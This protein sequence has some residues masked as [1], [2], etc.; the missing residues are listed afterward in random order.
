MDKIA[1]AKSLANDL[2]K[3]LCTLETIGALVAAAHLDAAVASLRQ[4][5]DIP[6]DKSEP[7]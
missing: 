7:E 2:E 1:I 5:F 4:T 3:H 6:V